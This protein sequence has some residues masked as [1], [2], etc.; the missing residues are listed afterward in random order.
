MLL[1]QGL[2]GVMSGKIVENADWEPE[3]RGVKI[4]LPKIPKLV[5]LWSL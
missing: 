4:H 5:P 1:C 3:E 2:H